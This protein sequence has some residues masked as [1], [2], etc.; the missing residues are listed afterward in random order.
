[1]AA[2]CGITGLRPTYGLVSRHGAMALSWTMDKLGPMAR[3]AEDC[4]LVLAVIAGKDPEDPSSVAHGFRVPPLERGRDAHR[5][6]IGVPKG[7]IDAVQG[8]VAENFSVAL[9]VLR[10]AAG[11]VE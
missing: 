4:A 11:G 6:R 3:S 1:P 10:G 9:E 7:A 8:E 5:F 2:Y